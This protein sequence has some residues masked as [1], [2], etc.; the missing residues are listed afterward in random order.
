MPV[1]L[2]I[3]LEGGD[4]SGKT[5]QLEA[6]ASRLR[7]RSIPVTTVREPGGTQLGVLLRQVLKFSTAPRT[8]RPSCF[9]STP[10]RTAGVGGDKPRP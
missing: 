5:T 10:P 3:T 2:F 4:G 6:L 1:G 8:R 9:Y 7:Q